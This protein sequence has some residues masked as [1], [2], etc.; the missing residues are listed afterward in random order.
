MQHFLGIDYGDKNIGVSMA[1]TPLAE[2]LTVLKNHPPVTQELRLLCQQHRIDTIIVGISEGQMAAKSRE[3]GEHLQP[4]TG[5]PV[6]F[7]DETLTSHEA[8]Q[9]LQHAKKSLR[10]KPQDAYQ[11]TLMLQDYLDTHPTSC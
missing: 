5:L 6:K 11:A 10:Q 4:A 1:T 9:K 8:N 7:H 3:F 2:P